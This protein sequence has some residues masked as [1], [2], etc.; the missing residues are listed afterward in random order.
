[1]KNYLL[2]LIFLFTIL[3]EG[4][5]FHYI[6]NPGPQI[7]SSIKVSK[8]NSVFIN[9]YKP[10]LNRINGVLIDTVFAEKKYSSDG[11][12]FSNYKIDSNNLQLIIVTRDYLVRNGKGFGVNWI[13]Q[14]F[15]PYS[16][17]IAY[18]DYKQRELPDSIIME[19]DSMNDGHLTQIIGK[20]TLHKVK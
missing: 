16:G 12:F 20:L 13:V 2:Y 15:N 4:C 9:A 19:I 1:M 10:N 8:A 5:Q 14:G 11:G 6:E 17:K 18:R 3:V 7:S